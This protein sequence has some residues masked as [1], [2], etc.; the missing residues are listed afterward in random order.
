MHAKANRIEACPAPATASAT[1][2]SRISSPARSSP[3]CLYSRGPKPCRSSWTRGDFSKTKN[4][5]TLLGYVIL[6]N[7]LHFIAAAENLG[8]RS[9][10]LQILHGQASS[11]SCLNAQAPKRCSNN[12]GT[13]SS[14]TR[15]ISTISFGKKAAS[16]KQIEND[17]MLLQKLEYMHNNPVKRGYVDDPLHWRYSSARNYARQPGLIEV[18]TDW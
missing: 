3:G 5:I 12:S 9:R 18:C 7:H 4:R 14:A 2:V 11:L 17:E 16:P 6:E 15:S 8:Q 13:T 10:R 1:T